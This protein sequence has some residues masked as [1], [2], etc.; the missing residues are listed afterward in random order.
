MNV[1]TD[2]SCTGNG[3]KNAVGGYGV[4]FEDVPEW[5]ISRRLV[6]V[7]T[8]NRAEMYAVYSC[9]KRLYHKNVIGDVHIHTD[10]KVVLFGVTTRKN[11][12]AN[13]DLWVKIYKML[14]LVPCK[15][16]FHKVEAHCGIP[17]NEMADRL[18][19]AGGKRPIN[20]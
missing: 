14:D 18:A 11:T 9:L 16:H 17:G 2:G 10:S 15:I 7:A 5:N 19:V 20:K 12:Y 6:G 1:Y 4:F 3:T 13:M 8:N